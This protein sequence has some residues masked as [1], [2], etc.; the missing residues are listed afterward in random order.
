MR[1]EWWW[2]L[3]SG[4]R[5][6]LGEAENVY[7]WVSGSEAA[8]TGDW[9]FANNA[10]HIVSYFTRLPGWYKLVADTRSA[11]VTAGRGTRARGLTSGGGGG[12]YE[13]A[14][15]NNYVAAS[16]TSDGRLAVLYLPA[17]ATVTIDEAKLPA[18]YSATWVDPITCATA[19]AATG[20]TYNS[21]TRGT[22]SQGDP[23]WVLVLQ[24]PLV[25]RPTTGLLLVGMI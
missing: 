13:P 21:A 20:S 6:V 22:N 9:F 7:P 11:F 14:F 17:H 12:E 19:A 2:T 4:A 5:G 16:I 25:V 24:A 1:Q 18:G 3:A 10:P 8:L 23:D 15:T